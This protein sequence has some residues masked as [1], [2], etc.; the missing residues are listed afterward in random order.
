MTVLSPSARYDQQRGRT[1]NTLLEHSLQMLKVL[2]QPAPQRELVLVGDSAYAALDFLSQMQ[3]L[4]IT[5][6]SRLRMEAALYAPAPAY[7]GRP[8]QERQT[9]AQSGTG[10][11]PSRHG[12]DARAIGLIRWAAAPDGHRFRLCCVVPHRQT[13]CPHPLGAG[14]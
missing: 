7:S 13:T 4:K 11:D 10:L 2:P 8:A 9:P 3:A 12:V 14:A 6:V 1:P 5:V